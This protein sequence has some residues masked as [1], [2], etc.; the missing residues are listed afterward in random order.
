MTT[1][2]HEQPLS[3]S[4]HTPDHAGDITQERAITCPFCRSSDT[5]PMS[6]FGSQLS[7]K[8]YYC[9][10]CHTPFEYIKQES[11]PDK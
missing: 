11:R 8:Q 2:K 5:E 1:N 6:L 3:T 4:M 7:T 10:A 9:R